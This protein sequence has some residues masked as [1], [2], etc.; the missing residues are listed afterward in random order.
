[1][2]QYI[3]GLLLYLSVIY[4][5]FLWYNP[6]K[7]MALVSPRDPSLA[8]SQTSLLIKFIQYSSALTIVKFSLSEYNIWIYVMAIVAFAFGQ[9]LNYKVYQLLGRD[10][11]YYGV[12]FGKKIPWVTAWPYSMMDNPQYIGCILTMVGALAWMPWHFTV[13]GI[14]SYLF[15]IYLE[16]E[17]PG[18]K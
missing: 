7:W 3:P 1:M 4:Y 17:I 10:G 12:R 5:A 18:S 9:L 15:M 13:N 11:V 6:H 2:W 16:S 14:I 8:M